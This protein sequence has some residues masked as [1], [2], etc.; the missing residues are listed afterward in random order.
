MWHYLL[1]DSRAKVSL[2]SDKIIK[3]LQLFMLITKNPKL[4]VFSRFDKTMRKT[5]IYFPP[6][7]ESIAQKHNA[8]SC[9]PP[10]RNEVGEVLAGDTTDTVVNSFFR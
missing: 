3:D 2:V 10:L 4:C 6:G 7:T 9:K 8:Q 5:H 1:I